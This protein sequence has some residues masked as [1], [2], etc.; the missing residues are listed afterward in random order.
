RAARVQTLGG[1]EAS[2][3][4]IGAVSPPGGDFSEPVTNHTKRH[5]GCF[6]GLDRERAQARFY[7]AIHPLQSYAVDAARFAGWWAAHGNDNW[8]R[9]REK[10]LALLEE[11]AHLERMARIVGKD[12]LPAEQQ[13]TLLAAELVNEALLRQSAFSEVDRYCS[14]E[15]Q[16]EMLR[17]VMRFI[18]LGREALARGASP[19]QVAALPVHRRL[20][21]M[22]EEI[23]EN[24]LGRFAELWPELERE[25]A[26]LGAAPAGAGTQEGA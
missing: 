21:R 18:A 1:L 10:L 26:A 13:L 7:P 17:L 19:E 23:G 4:I 9:Q 24:E 11:Q 14:A 5:V 3:T 6:W 16:S 8:L 2:L 12:A 25:C 15:R 20:Q 22:G